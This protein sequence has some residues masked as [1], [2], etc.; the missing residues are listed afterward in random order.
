MTETSMKAPA[1]TPH[2]GDPQ[3]LPS[4]GAVLWLAW[5]SFREMV[6]RKRLFGLSAINLIPVLVVLSIRIWAK[7]LGISPHLQL[8]GLTH[9]IFIEFLI[10]IAAM[11]MAIPAIGE[12]VDDG[13][14]V[15]TWSRPVKRWA[16]YLG[17]LLAAQVVSTVVMSGALVLCFFIMVSEGTEVITF[18]FIKVYVVT[19][20]IIALGAFTYSALF[21]AMGTF[22]RKPVLPAILFTFGWES[23]VSNIPARVQE[24]SLRFHL[25]N[26]IERPPAAPQDLPGVLEALLSTAFV[27]DPVPKVQSIAVLL[28]VTALA[29]LLGAW[30]LK[31]KEIEN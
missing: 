30:L 20:M 9:D 5:F 23:M 25:Q 14:I 16:I 8:A 28:V 22:F 15:F 24:V 1:A 31:H 10:P 18:E 12:Q 3:P 17:R 2:T 6:R 4:M 11:A 19:F 27:R 21:A 13:T 7:D 26:L 29:T